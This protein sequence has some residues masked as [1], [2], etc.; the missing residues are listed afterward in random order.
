MAIVGVILN[1]I[2]MK[3]CI[4]YIKCQKWL[5]SLSFLGASSTGVVTARTD[6]HQIPNIVES[7]RSRTV[8]CTAAPTVELGMCTAQILCRLPCISIPYFKLCK[9]LSISL[10]CSHFSFIAHNYFWQFACELECNTM[11]ALQ[12]SV[13]VQWWTQMHD[14]RCRGE[15]QVD[16]LFEEQCRQRYRIDRQKRWSGK[17]TVGLVTLDTYKRK[18][19]KERH[20]RRYNNLATGEW[21]RWVFIH[22]GWEDNYTQVNHI[23]AGTGN[24]KRRENKQRQEDKWTGAQTDSKYLNK[25]GSPWNK[26]KTQ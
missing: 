19:W 11:N 9:G 5:L 21:M 24:H 1:R 22:G 25:T 16:L 4:W 3:K 10:S 26:Q 2:T 17:Q 18:R 23:R 15:M 14:S 12:E 7:L 20:T 6:T 13:R 8:R